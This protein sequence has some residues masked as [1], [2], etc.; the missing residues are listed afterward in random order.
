MALEEDENDSYRSNTWNVDPFSRVRKTNCLQIE[1]HRDEVSI[2]MTICF[3]FFGP[4]R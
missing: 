4:G 2:S 1:T 3:E